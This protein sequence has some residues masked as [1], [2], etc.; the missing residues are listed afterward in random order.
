M[1][2]P[3]KR[4]QFDVSATYAD[5]KG[6]LLLR[7]ILGRYLDVERID[8]WRPDFKPAKAYPIRNLDRGG[9][10][11]AFLKLALAIAFFIAA[12]IYTGHK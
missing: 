11:Q 4:L 2:V 7:T 12:A 1:E 8:A 5:F 9:M 6:A 3:G 10:I